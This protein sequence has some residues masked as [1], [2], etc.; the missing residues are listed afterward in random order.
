MIA[1]RVLCLCVAVACAGC[2]DDALLTLPTSETTVQ[3]R[4]FSGVLA[5]KGTRFYSYTVVNGG[6]VSAMLA[7]LSPAG[8]L[9]PATNR[10]NLGFG[11]P[12]GTG[13]ALSEVINVA[14]ALVAQLTQT[15]SPGTHCVSV[16]DVDGLPTPMNFSVRLVLP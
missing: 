3:T 11:I 2:G 12:A 10:L 14:P 13:C 1:F 9:I 8:S 5:Q 7:S 4:L 15:A 16:T 6:A